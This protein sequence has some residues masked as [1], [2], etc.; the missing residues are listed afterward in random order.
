MRTDTLRAAVAYLVRVWD[1]VRSARS[2]NQIFDT[3]PKQAEVIRF[4]APEADWHVR[5]GVL[6]IILYTFQLLLLAIVTA[7]VQ[8]VLH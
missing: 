3:L 5:L 7:F 6:A 1:M 4:V 8:V 2:W